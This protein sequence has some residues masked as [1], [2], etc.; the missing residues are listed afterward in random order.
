[1]ACDAL[2]LAVGQKPDG[3]LLEPGIETEQ[4]GL[5]VDPDT[6]ATC[7]R[8]LFA[9]GDA[10]SGPATVV[11][12]IAA[13]RRAARGVNAFLGGFGPGGKPSPRLLNRWG[14]NALKPSR[15]QEVEPRPPA[16]RTWYAE[17]LGGL[18]ADQTLTEAGRCF[19]CGCVAVCA[20]DLAPVLTALEAKMVTGKRTIPA[21]A[22]FAA[23]PLSSTVLDVGELVTGVFLPNRRNLM[24]SYMKFRI[25]NAI[26]FP[27]ASVAVAL[28][29]EGSTVRT[30]R[31][32]LGAAAPVPLR[33]RRAERILEG[34]KPGQAEAE[35]AAK[36]AVEGTVPLQGNEYKVSVFR[37]L[38]KRAI[39][40][41]LA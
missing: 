21:E 37:A 41:A 26:D 1:V 40:E 31:I 12:A 35:A 24:T 16:D 14:E 10:V 36:A 9:G 25:R 38:V 11:E 18:D 34:K 32:V 28:E 6:Q 22:F 30:A 13:G 29:M 17:D 27:I 3:T 33:A 8:G 20:S 23:N 39:A 2:I 7:V 19:N 15:R 4:G 5:V